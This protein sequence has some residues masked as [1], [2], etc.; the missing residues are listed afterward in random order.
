MRIALATLALLTGCS[1]SMCRCFPPET[2]AGPDAPAPDTNLPFD[3]GPLDAPG[4]AA[5]DAGP[6]ASC[7][8]TCI[9]QSGIVGEGDCTTVL[10]Y[11][12]VITGDLVG[13]CRPVSGCT[14]A[15]DCAGLFPTAEA[16]ARGNACTRLC[17]GLTADGSPACLGDEY[18]SYEGVTACGGDDSTG[19]CRPRPTE[20]PGP[21]GDP[22]CGCDGSEYATGCHARMAGTDVAMNAP[23]P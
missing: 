15:G 9:D 13:Y 11:A 16:C 18:C 2:D 6:G 12:F 20:C 4:L 14:C 10:G 17:G 8:D 21:G 19:L 5:C 22:I 23:C 3:S 1:T 7:T